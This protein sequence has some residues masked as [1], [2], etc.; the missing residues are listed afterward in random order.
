MNFNSMFD[1]KHIIQDKNNALLNNKV[2]KS[3]VLNPKYASRR[4]P[5]ALKHHNIE[6]QVRNRSEDIEKLL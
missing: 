2:S 3:N 6:T 1:D 4:N 5:Y